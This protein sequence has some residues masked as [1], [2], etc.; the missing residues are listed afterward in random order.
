MEIGDWLRIDMGIG[1]ISD[2]RIRKLR[3]T[4]GSGIGGEYLGIYR[5]S[6]FYFPDGENRRPTNNRYLLKESLVKCLSFVAPLPRILPKTPIAL[7][8]K[9]FYN[10]LGMWSG[11]GGAEGG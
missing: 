7:F 5:D 4:I 3:I 2:S 1:D 11:G 9:V 10:K 8:K 6:Y